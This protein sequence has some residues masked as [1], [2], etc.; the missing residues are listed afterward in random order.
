LVEEVYNFVKF[1]TPEKSKSI[2]G[3]EIRVSKSRITYSKVFDKLIE[4]PEKV[5]LL[6]DKAKNA[7]AIAPDNDEGIKVQR[8]AKSTR[9]VPC[10]RFIQ[11]N[12]ILNGI[13]RGKVLDGKIIFSKSGKIRDR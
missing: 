9:D 11:D 3:D 10:K 8:K 7:Y 13:Y 4:S 1:E 5:S 12:K 2:S 6:I